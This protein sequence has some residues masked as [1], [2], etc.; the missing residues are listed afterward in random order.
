MT[1]EAG[2]KVADRYL[3]R[4][5]VGKGGMGVVWQAWDEK[6]RR[7]VAVKC[8]RPGDNEA[9][10]RLEKEAQL[11]ARLHHAN[12]VPVFDFVEEEA[13]WIVME[14]VP[15]RSLAQ[16]VTE[17]GL[18]TPEA[19]GSVGC[20]IAAALAKSHAEGVVHGD[21][22]PENILVTDDG[23]ARLM[24]FGIARA[25]WSD[26]TET[27]TVSG[28]VRGK[29]KYLAPE[30]ARGRTADEKADVFSLGASLF[31]A[32]EGRSPY[33]EAG[34]ALEYLARAVEEHIEPAERAGPLTAPLTALLEVDPRRRP[35]AAEAHRLLTRAAPPPPQV[36]AK[37]HDGR[38][39]ALTLPL[40]S[41][42]GRLP[43]SVRRRRRPLA[44]V[45]GVLV[46]A[47]AITAGLLVRAGDGSG[48]DTTSSDQK[49]PA[50]AGLAGT[51]GD[52]RGADPCTLLD[53]A[54]LSR[55][56]D[57]RLVSDYGEFNRC[58]VLVRNDGGD[59]VA[60]A[61]VYLDA[62]PAEFDSA[63]PT[64]RVGNITVASFEREED[65][66]VRVLATAD[67]RQI[68]VIGK[69]LDTPAPDLCAL[70][71]AATDHAVG[72]LDDAPVPRRS[73]QPAAN[74]LARVDACA[75]LD[76]ATLRQ[77]PGVDARNQRRG[78][79]SWSCGWTSDDGDSEVRV[80]YSRDSSMGDEGTP[81][82]IAGT[83]GYLWPQESSDDSCDV[84][85]PHRTYTNSTGDRTI[86]LLHLTVYSPQPID[87]LCNSAKALAAT[88]TRNIAERLPGK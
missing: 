77:I 30:L 71:D 23:V 53:S 57:T 66:C 63:V 21:V 55:F 31:A 10:K 27:Q 24:D 29:P 19:A 72:V 9:A 49:P 69:Q 52:T 8:A 40:Q 12:I 59:E 50:T 32:V 7:R 6:L 60:D 58:D 34:N 39:L 84:R 15:S 5:L 18:L 26:V 80:E 54:S 37:L 74:S 3:L 46:L 35:N 79:G 22:T 38:T 16:V 75:L 1:P 88:I 65:A 2:Y 81:T 45:W 41:L 70:A 11:A 68:Q 47:S 78:F 42:V 61:Q 20:Q 87:Q 48:S 43:R 83:K 67:H 76:P 13:C 56:G 73:S 14:F 17:D 33:G 4:E 82:D 25:L 28:T 36:R 64:R 51:I 85:T 62:E 44:V 86:E